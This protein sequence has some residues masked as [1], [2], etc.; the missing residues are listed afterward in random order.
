MVF[1]EINIVTCFVV[2]KLGEEVFYQLR[3]FAHT[4]FLQH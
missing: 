2:Y 4:S 3:I 1:L